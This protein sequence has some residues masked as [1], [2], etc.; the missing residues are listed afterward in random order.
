MDKKP[1]DLPD[2]DQFDEEFG[3]MDAIK[4]TPLLVILAGS[5]LFVAVVMFF[6]AITYMLWISI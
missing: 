2:F 5:M 3:E 1:I 6:L 4:P